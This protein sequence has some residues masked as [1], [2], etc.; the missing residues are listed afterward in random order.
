MFITLEQ[1]LKL[2]LDLKKEAMGEIWYRDRTRQLS[3]L[4][5][6]VKNHIIE[7]GTNLAEFLP[8]LGSVCEEAIC[9]IAD[10]FEITDKTPS[11][12]C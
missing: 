3:P 1:E 12:D 7:D 5:K 6:F 4:A 11:K 10:V 8:I 9:E 2:E